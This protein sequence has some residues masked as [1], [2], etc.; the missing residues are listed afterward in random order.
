M[1]K[2][3]IWNEF[4][5]EQLDEKE[6]DFVNNWDEKHKN[7]MKERAKEI[8]KV[9]NGAIHNTLRDLFNEDEQ[10]EVKHIGTL[11]MNDCGLTDEVLNDT[12]VLVWW[13]HIAQDKVPDEIVKRVHNHVL[14]GMGIIFLHSAHMSKPM[15]SLLGTSCT[16]R[17]REGDSENLWT[18]APTHPIA[19]GVKECVKLDEE[20]MYGE[21]FDIPTPDELVFISSFA[22]GEVF[23]SG[24]V[25]RRG[26]GKIFYFQAG[27]ETNKSYFN[28]DVRKI[29]KNAVKYVNSITERK[30]KIECLAV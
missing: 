17:W 5:Q 25:W 15:Q 4:V 7:E 1:I 14:R 19:E 24:C 23:R 26:Y 16:L 12:D 3:T 27:H 30:N 29:L 9:H 11:E 10:I 6:F 2:V 13:S 21:F 22:G 20:E 18:V 28:E 8:K